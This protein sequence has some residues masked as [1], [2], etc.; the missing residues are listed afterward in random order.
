MN[1]AEVRPTGRYVLCWL[2]QALRARDNPVIDA[3]IRLGNDLGLPVL[4]YHGLREDFPYASDRLHRF[5]LGA[6][7]D[8]ARDCRQRGLACVQHVD[9]D[10]AREKGL[11]YRLAADS[12]AV[13]VED[14]PTFVARW[15]SDRVAARTEVAMFAVNAACLVP[16]ALLGDG[17]GSTT[18]FRR[19]HEAV[20]ADWLAT[21]DLQ[22]DIAAYDGPPALHVR[23][24]RILQRR[25]P[26]PAGRER[27]D[28][29]FA[30]AQ[31]GLPGRSRG[32]AKQA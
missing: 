14:Q 4:V 13:F 30:C 27:G 1:A 23:S 26:G 11:V 12:A 15:Q 9:R 24:S 20:R 32:R 19:R 21:D 2:Q 6:S 16:P 22:A 31:S 5:I 18:A 10:D 29:S 8:L 3:A 17:I 28:R 7:R 25:R